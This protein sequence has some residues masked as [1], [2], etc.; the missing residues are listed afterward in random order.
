MTAQFIFTILFIMLSHGM[1]P[2]ITSMSE[3]LKIPL[4]MYEIAGAFQNIFEQQVGR[5][6]QIG[7]SK[8]FTLYKFGESGLQNYPISEKFDTKKLF[9]GNNCVLDDIVYED[10]IPLF[11]IWKEINSEKKSFVIL[12]HKDM[13]KLNGDEWLEKM[14]SLTKRASIERLKRLDDELFDHRFWLDK[15]RENKNTENIF[16]KHLSLLRSQETPNI[17]CKLDEQIEKKYLG[18]LLDDD[19][20]LEFPQLEVNLRTKTNANSYWSKNKK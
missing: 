9:V 18:N 10:G 7:N 6:V 15:S 1:E 5:V 3:N 8:Q 4:G 17:D 12:A 2:K 19:K 14:K 16:R 13:Q 11:I 20:N